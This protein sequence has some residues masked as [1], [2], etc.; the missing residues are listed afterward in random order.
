LRIIDADS[1]YA[2]AQ[3]LLPTE[4]KGWLLPATWTAIVTKGN[5]A[6]IAR[7]EAKAPYV[8]GSVKTAFAENL[9]RYARA[10]QDDA[11]FER[12][13]KLIMELT[14]NEPIRIYRY[15]VG[16]NMFELQADYREEADKRGS[17]SAR[18]KA[19]LAI[20]ERYTSLILAEEKEEENIRLYKD[21]GR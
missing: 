18:A 13:L 21:I 12:T 3:R 9:Q 11:L 14:R 4:P 10:V 1:A 6:D 19:R 17:D 8:Y 5:P 2:I 20:V 7:F 16:A 15:V